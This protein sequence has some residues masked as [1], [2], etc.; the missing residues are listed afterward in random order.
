M[1]FSHVFDSV[2]GVGP[3]W[4]LDPPPP[5]CFPFPDA[6]LRDGIDQHSNALFLWQRFTSPHLPVVHHQERHPGRPAQTH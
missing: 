2:V 4:L 6:R 3:P 5:L 1:Y